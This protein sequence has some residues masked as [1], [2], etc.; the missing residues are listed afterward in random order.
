[1]ADRAK[2][3]VTS[4]T[5]G[6]S[7]PSYLT[8]PAQVEGTNRPI[9]LVVSLHPWSSDLDGSHNQALEDLVAENGWIYLWPNFR[10]RNDTPEA[11]G[12]VLAQQD[13]LDAIDWVRERYSLSATFLTGESGGGHMTML[14]VG[15]FPERWTAA[16]AWVGISDLSAWYEKHKD[17]KYGE[18]IRQ[19]AG[20][21]PGDSDEIDDALT[22]RSPLTHLGHARDV[23]LEIAAGRHD[24]HTGSV[25]IRQSLNAFNAIAEA[26]GDELVTE[27]EIDQMSRPD[28]HLQTPRAS[29]EV[30]DDAFARQIFLR[31]QSGPIRVTIFE[32]GHEGIATATMAWFERH[33]S[34]PTA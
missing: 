28:G 6:S 16:I 17:G 26:R 29:D 14:M 30:S 34:A 24:G 1:M 22:A 7:Q 10:G 11:M 21:T 27:D 18:M 19:C 23:P 32:G 9:P 20:G 5:D 12:S 25:P 13:I 33:L 15:R 3:Q 2:I 4:S 31:R 8:V